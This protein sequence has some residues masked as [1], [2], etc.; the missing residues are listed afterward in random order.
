M[1]WFGGEIFAS[2]R[3]SF[4]LLCLALSAS[5]TPPPTG[6]GLDIVFLGFV[7]SAL[8][9]HSCPTLAQQALLGASPMSFP[10][11]VLKIAHRATQVRVSFLLKKQVSPPPKGGGARYH[12]SWVCPARPQLAHTAS[13]GPA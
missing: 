13:T 8:F 2:L 12:P 5:F 4:F 9:V 10:H 6:E 1:L 7:E 3:A 11:S